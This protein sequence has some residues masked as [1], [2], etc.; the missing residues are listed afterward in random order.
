MK[1]VYLI[2]GWGGH[3][4]EHFFS[5]LDKELKNKGFE[6]IQPQMPGTDYP[7]IE[8][9]VSF[10]SNLVQ[11]PDKKTFFVG[12]SIGCQTIMRYLE[13]LNTPVGGAVFVAGW[14]DLDNLETKEEK[15]VRKPWVETPIDFEKIKTICPKI[16]V[17]LSDN[18][19]FGFVKENKK[20]FE[21]KLNAKVSIMENKGHF[22]ED[23]G[24]TKLPEVL[25]AIEE[26]IK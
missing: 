10:L 26:M 6:V 1:K 20:I 25:Q 15:D 19:P 18:E 8:E 21:E 7:K 22:C 16:S 14:F 17:L 9:W 24:V 13:M 5:W 11:N 12:H 4:N 2:H 23:D 3:P